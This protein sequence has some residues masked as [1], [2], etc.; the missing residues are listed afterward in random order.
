MTRLTA[1]PRKALS[2][3]AIA[4]TG[5][6]L[7]VSAAP[8]A[9]ADPA[10][11]APQVIPQPA[12]MTVDSGHFTLGADARVVAAGAGAA[13][14]ANDLAAALRPATGYRLPVGT[15]QPRGGDIS[16]AIGSAPGP[17]G[18]R[19]QVSG[20]GVSLVA[21]TPHGLFN[22]VQTIRQLLPPWIDSPTVRHVAW[23]MPAMHITDSPRYQ[24][25][26]V[27]LDIAR[28]FEPPSAVM[29][30]IDQA[31]AYK[32][33]VLHLHVSDDQGF[34][35]VI[36]GFPNLTNIGGQGS[37]GTGGRTMDP[38]GFW[39]QA[40]YKEV[41]AYAAAHFMTVVPEVDTP[42]HNNAI[43][44]S[45]YNDTSNPLLNGHPQ[46]INCSTNDPPVWNFTG[47]VGY[48]ALCPESDNTWTIL[49]A[50]IA[51]LS[52][53]SPGPY[54][55]IGG[56][57]VPSTVLTHDR[58]AALVNREGGVV[59]SHG[60]TVMGWAEISGAGTQLAPGSVAE[61]WNPAS[62][63]DAGTE[64]ATNAVQKGMKI[65]MA[66]ATHAYLDQKYAPG[67]PSSL[68]LSWACNSGCDVDQFYNWDP[69]S[70]VD[71]VTDDDVIGVE[72][73]M[74]AETVVNPSNIDY[75]V[76]P[77]L[78]AL[79]ELGWSPQADRTGKSSPAY[80]DF[81]VRLAAQGARWLAAG[82]NFYPTPEVPWRLDAAAG[83]PTVDRS[84]TVSGALAA[85]SAPGFATGALS[86]T[87][88]WGD[89]T[90]S[91]AVLSGTPST[92]TTVNGLYSVAATHTYSAH[93][94][95]DVQVTITAA[96][97][98]PAVVNLTLRSR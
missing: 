94:A 40:E 69:G 44:M 92:S 45:E 83:T 37:V 71:G 46:D 10:D 60:K 31:S 20:A 27:M 38:G 26:G 4:V 87:V 35:I 63:S 55:N 17:E 21:A 86:A 74:W 70:Y 15:G 5:L 98:F 58:Y 96:G 62:G 8:S 12:Q 97:T 16:L 42:G 68:G 30:L 9:G 33:N 56:D 47:D 7:A 25:R 82:T 11:P 85:V 57:E 90:T 89:G 66:P 39:T 73:A 14:V 18:Y 61:Y 76:F 6:G 80:Q 50:I 95:F 67:I 93:G 91:Q 28:H 36:N 41:V 43:I 72:G 65:V 84:G 1:L 32:I 23:T 54:Y 81:V 51:Q 2:L 49:S 3:V 24:Y 22:G 34:R 19:L 13:A 75:M 53:M 77:R 52:A 59:N 29:R 64:T 88:D 78:P 48:S 79:A